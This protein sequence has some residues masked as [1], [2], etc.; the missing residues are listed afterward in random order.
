MLNLIESVKCLSDIM[1]RVKAKEAINSFITIT[2]VYDSVRFTQAGHDD[3]HLF[4]R[5]EL[6]QWIKHSRLPK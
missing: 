4:S 3:V 2:D 1:N 6:K 5:N